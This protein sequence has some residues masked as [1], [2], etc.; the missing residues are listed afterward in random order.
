[1]SMFSRRGLVNSP[2]TSVSFAFY[3]HTTTYTQKG[4]ALLLQS[5]GILFYN[6]LGMSWSLAIAEIDYWKLLPR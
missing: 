6:N 5:C 1:M 2:V 4:I 3:L